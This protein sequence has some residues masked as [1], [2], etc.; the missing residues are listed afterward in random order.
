MP[1]MMLPRSGRSPMKSEDLP[2]TS[3]WLL[4]KLSQHMKNNPGWLNVKNIHRFAPHFTLVIESY[5]LSRGNLRQLLKQL[6][7]F[8]SRQG[9]HD[10]CLEMKS[11]LF[12]NA[13]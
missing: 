3:L 13:M 1:T 2:I 5:G 7:D 6:P 12:P 10:G 8:M 11:K 9:N 4:E